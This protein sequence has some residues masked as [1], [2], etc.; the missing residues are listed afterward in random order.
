MKL[1]CDTTAIGGY[2]DVVALGGEGTLTSDQRAGIGCAAV[3]KT[4]SGS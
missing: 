1:E 4:I 3:C 2:R